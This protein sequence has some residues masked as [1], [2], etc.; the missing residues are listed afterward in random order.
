MGVKEWVQRK[1][2]DEKH[3]REQS[4]TVVIIMAANDALYRCRRSTPSWSVNEEE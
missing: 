4:R 1:T 3:Q 2:D